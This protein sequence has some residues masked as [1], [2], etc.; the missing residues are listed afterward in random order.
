LRLYSAR[1]L[2]P[3]TISPIREGAVVLGGGD[4]TTVIAVGT[5]DDLRRQHA[6]I[7]EI[8]AEGALCPA[9]VNAHVHLELSSLAAPI[10]GGEGVVKW[11]RRLAARLGER[12]P[13]TIPEAAMRAAR[14]AKAFGTAAMGDVGNGTTG[15]R[16]L[17]HAGLGGVF[18]HELVGSR[19][20]RT[21]DAILDAIAERALVLEAERPAGVDV[22]PAPHAPYSVGPDLMRRIFSTAAAAGRATTIHLAEDPDELLLLRE[23]SGAWPET[24][25]AMGVEPAERTPRLGPTEYLD[26]LGAFTAAPAPL[27]VHMVHADADDR[28]R[29][30]KAR[31]TVV[32]CP[33]SNLH[34]GGL[35]PDVPALIRDGVDLAVGTDGLASTPDLSPWA[36]IATLASHFP[37]VPARTWLHAATLG[38]AA[39]LGLVPLGSIEC[40]KRPGLIDV[41]LLEGGD[42]ERAIVINP[43]PPVRWM[44][45]A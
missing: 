21:G 36:E 22:V 41:G 42:P 26:S 9:L 1:W 45:S 18:F 5:R 13:R 19:E 8:R 37:D 20:S 43:H 29:A 7:P 23:G 11:T 15:W 24:L 32:L 35:L 28:R 2:V 40:G 3:I 10:P 30:R 33:R 38:G 12:D 34:I 44:A 27:L 4:G 39:A 31:A 25:R 14:A 6:G 17:A 16:A